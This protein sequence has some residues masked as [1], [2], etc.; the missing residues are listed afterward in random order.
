MA[1]SLI[2]D[3]LPGLCVPL[4]TRLAM[5]VDLPAS[6][7]VRLYV[8]HL[9]GTFPSLVVDGVKHTAYSNCTHHLMLFYSRSVRP[10]SQQ[11][12]KNHAILR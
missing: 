12:K 10:I 11:K 8:V 5:T 6:S 9:V 7:S 2:L 1:M 4:A 3:L